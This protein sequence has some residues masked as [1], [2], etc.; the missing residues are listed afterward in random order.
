MD[1][2]I[3]GLFIVQ[4]MLITAISFALFL[5]G[6]SGSFAS[7]F[8]VPSMVLVYGFGGGFTY[9][10]VHLLKD[11]ELGV[12]QNEKKSCYWHQRDDEDGRVDWENMS[13]RQIF[14]LIRAT[15]VP[16]KGAFTF[17]NKKKIRIFK[18]E[19]VK[20][21]IKGTPGKILIIQGKGPFVVCNDFAI[22]LIKCSINIKNFKHKDKFV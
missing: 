8:S 20:K 14:N 22:K 6:S 13:A 18:V 9:M 1:N 15:T 3:I 21:I 11:G 10:R 5:E 19:L 16:L 4:I 12:V 17:L 2:R 7:F